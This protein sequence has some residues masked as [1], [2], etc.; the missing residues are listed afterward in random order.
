M[1]QTITHFLSLLLYG[2]F[3]VNLS[4]QAQVAGIY[5]SYIA[6]N[7]NGSGNQFYDLAASTSNPDF[8]GQNL[9][10]F[11]NS[12]SLIISGGQNKTFKS[13]SGGC[14][15]SNGTLHY[16]LYPTASPSGVF[17]GINLLFD[18]NLSGSPIGSQN[19]QWGMGGANPYLTTPNLLTGLTNGDYTLEVYTS[20]NYE[21]CAGNSPNTG[22]AFSSNFGANFKAEF[23]VFNPPV[24]GTNIP[25]E[26][27]LSGNPASE[28]DLPTPTAGDLSIQGFATDISYNRG[29]TAVFKIKTDASAY[30]IKIYRLGYYQGNG[31]RYIADATITTTLP[32][33]QPACITETSTA[34]QLVDCGN[35]AES[36]TWNIP[37]NA[38]SG[39]YI[40]KLIRTDNGGAS[41]IAFIVRNDASTSDLLFQTS[42]ATWQ[43]YNGYDEGSNNTSLYTGPTSL[44]S[45][46]SGKVSYNRPFTTRSGGAGG[47][48][49]E[50]WLFNSEY[51]MIRWL[52]RNGY[53]VSYTT[54]IDTDRHGDLIVNHK[55][56]LSV[57]HDEYWSKGMKDKVTAA[58][59]AGV[60]LAFFSGNEV[61][62]KTRWENSIDGNGTPFRTLVCYKEGPGGEN[63]TEVK[64]DPS[65]EW[66]GLWRYGC[67][68]DYN[69][70][71]NNA[72]L[73]ENEL[74]GQVS[75]DGTTGTMVV[76]SDYK[77]LR[78]WR[79]TDVAN[80]PNGQTLTLTQN[81]LGYEWD[82]E[83]EEFRAS[84]P[85]GRILLSKTI[86]ND[87]THHLSLYKH[88]SGAL[89]FGA[90]TVQ[91]TWGLDE[92]HDRFNGETVSV[93]MQQATVNV[94]ADMDVQATTLQSGL[95]AA[96]AST[97]TQA[98]ISIITNPLN[99][100]DIPN[101]TPIIISGTASD[102][103]GVLAGVEVS[104]DNGT[105]WRVATGAT[106]WTFSWIPTNLG[107]AII[108]VR[109]FDDSGNIE[110]P[111]TVGSNVLTV[112]V[113]TPPPPICPCNV[114]Q[115]STTP[116]NT[117][118]NDGQPIQVG[119]KFRSSIDGFIS[120]ARFYKQ[121]GN[122]GTH[123][124]Q[125]YSNTGAL[126]AQATFIN[127]SASA[128]QEVAFST[129]IAIT[130]NTIYIISYHSAS[131]S[132]SADDNGFV[133]GVAN[134]NL[135]AFADSEVS[136]GN[137]VYKYGALGFP[138]L[139]FEESNYF[140]DVVFNTEIGPD[141]TPPTILLTSPVDNVSNV[142][143][144]ANITVTFS[145]AINPTTLDNSTFSVN[146]V[147]GAVTY[148][149]I[150]KT[151]TFNPNSALSYA[152]TYTATVQGDNDGVEDL[153]GNKIEA[154]FIFSFTTQNAPPPALPDPN[155]GPGGPIL[156]VSSA[157]NPFSRFAVEILRAEGLNEFAGKD[158]S[159]V[160]ASLLNNYDIV[161]LGEMPLN[162]S[163]VSIFSDWV[164]AGGT[165]ITF[166]P[167]ADLATLLGINIGGGTLSDKYLAIANSGAGAGIVNQS[168]Q[169]HGEADLYSLNGA[170]SLATLYSSANTATTNPA[171]T[172]HN[173]GTNGGKAIAFAF[174]LARS[175][176][177]T[178][179]GNPDWAGQKRDGE[180]QP[181]RS[182][183]LFFPDWIDFNKVQ[184]PQADE[185]QRF[186][187]NLIL[188]S[189]AHRKPLPRFWYLPR[190]L[191]AA[192][193]MTGDDHASGGTVGRFNQYL[194]LSSSNT[195][196]AV[197][198]W[199]AIRGTSYIYPNTPM[200]DAE[201]L[202]FENQGF[203]ISL[204]LNTNCAVWVPTSLRNFFDTQMADLAAQF[205]SISPPSTHRTHCI[206]W[207]D[208][209]TTPIVQVERGIRLDANYYY[210]PSAWVQNRPGMF[211]GSGMPMR[212]ADLD[213]TL[214]DCYQL[215]TQLTDESGITY[216]THINTLLDNAI[217]ANG[218]YGVFCANMHTDQ[219]GGNSTQGSNAIISSAQA[220]NIPVIAA[221]QMLTWLDGRNNS[222]FG[223]ITWNGNALSFTANI[224][225]GANLIYGMLPANHQGGQL[226]S[227]TF[228]GGAVSFT[229]E[230]IKG[231]EYAFF[232]VNNGNYVATYGIDNVPPQIT[233]INANPSQGGNATITW[234]TD[235]NATSQVIYGTD[236]NNLNLS[237]SNSSPTTNHSL[238]LTGLADNTQ[239]YYRVISTDASANTGTNPNPPA[240]PLSF[241][242]PTPPVAPCVQDNVVADF[243]LGTSDANTI[244]LG[245][246][247][248]EVS[249]KPAVLEEFTVPS[250]PVGWSGGTW[251]SGG[252]TTFTNGQITVNGTNIYTNSSFEAGTTLEFAATF[253]QGNFQN[254]GFSGNGQFNDPWVVIGRGN[255]GGD[256]GLYARGSSGEAVLLGS[257]LLNTLHRYKIQW[258]SNGSFQFYVD[259][260][261]INAAGF[262]QTVGGTTMIIQI[263]DF[264]VDGANLSVDW[265]SSTP[266]AGSGTFTSRIFDASTA[267]NWLQANW[268]AETPAGT[269]LQIFQRQGNTTTPDGTWTSFTAITNGANVGGT[270]RYI[271]YQMN[272]ATSNTTVS[273]VFKDITIACENPS[274]TTPNIT[275]Q[276]L[277]QTKC[278]G[279]EVTFSSTASGLPEPTV[280]W[281]VSTDNGDN[282]NDI[283]G[284]TNS[285]L[286]FNTVI[287]DN[288]KKY[289]AVWTNTQG[290]INSDEVILT[291]QA[292][293]TATI[294]L[295][296]TQLCEGENITLQLQNAT[297]TAPFDL[298]V[299]GISY[300]DV[301]IGQTFA[302]IDPIPTQSIWDNS[303]VPTGNL[304]VSDGQALEI[305]VK[306]RTSANGYV[307]GVRFYK[308]ATNI[309][310]HIGK[311]W[312]VNG[313]LLANATF[314]NETAEGWQE[315]R[316]SNPVWIQANTT[317][318]ASYFSQNG[319][320][321]ILGGGMN[322]GFTNGNIT[323]L[324]NGTDGPNSV[325]N[326]VGG[327]GGFPDQNGS[328]ANYW[329]DVVFSASLSSPLNS[330]FALTSITDA[331]NCI[332]TGTPLQNISATVN[333]LP[334]GTIAPVQ[335]TV[336]VGQNVNLIFNA[337]NGTAPFDLT[338]NGNVYSGIQ[339]N[340]PFNV[341]VP[342]VSAPSPISIWD[343]NVIGGEPGVVDNSALELGVKFRSHV[344]GKIKGI[345][346][347]KRPLNTGTH[348][349][350]L[351]TLGGT[352]LAT[353]T[354]INESASGWQEVLFDTPVSIQANTTYIASYFAPG[355][356][357]AFTV[358]FFTN[359]GLSN[360]AL[361][362][363]QSGESGSGANGVF[364]EGA[365]FP[366]NSFNDANYWVD[367][368]FVPDGQLLNYNL[369]QIATEACSNT[370][371]LNTVVFVEFDNT[372]PTTPVLSVGTITENSIQLNWT[373]SMDNVEVT[374]YE[375]FQNNVSIGTTANLT[376][377]VSGLTACTAY[378]FTVKTKDAAGNISEASNVLNASTTDSTAPT[379]P[380]LAD[381]TGE[382]AVTVTAPTTTDNCA[383]E[384]IGTTS[385]PLEY[386]AQGTYQITWTFDDGNGNSTQAVQNVVVD[387]VTAPVT[388]VL[389]DATGECA[390][391]VT[392][393]TT[394][395]VCAG[396]IT[397]TTT[398]ALTYTAQGTYQ[399][400]W[401][402]DDGN[403]NS[404]TA[405]QN[406]VVDDVTPPAT[407]TL[408]DA[409]SECAV[410]VTAPTTTDNCA[411]TITGTT[412]DPLD[413]T[414]QGT[415]Q[416]TWTF[417]DGN[418]NSTTAIQNVV[419]DDVTTPVTPTLADAT[420]E[421][422]LTITAPT[423]TDNC[424]GTITGTTSDPLDYTAQGTYQITW[425][426]DDGNGNSTTAIQNVVVNPLTGVSIGS[427]APV[428]KDTPAFALTG[429]PANGTFSGTGVSNGV[430]NPCTAGAGSHTITYTYT[431]ES[432]CTATATTS[433]QVND[434]FC[435][436]CSTPTNVQVAN[437][438][439]TTATLSW[440]VVAGATHYRLRYRVV[441]N[442][443]WQLVQV[444]P[445][446]PYTL[447]GLTAN[448]TYEFQ[449]R[450][451][452]CGGRTSGFSPLQVFV[453][454]IDTQT[455]CG[456]P[457]NISTTNITANSA[458]ASWTAIAS[459]VN[460][461]L[462][463]RVVGASSWTF[464]NTIPSNTQILNGLTATTNYEYQVRSECGG[465]VVSTYSGMNYFTTTAGNAGCGVPTNLTVS[466]ISTSGVT[467][468]WTVVGG[469]TNYRLRYRVVGTT[470][471]LYRTT[472]PTS[473]FVLNNLLANTSYEY[474]LRAECSGVNGN[475]TAIQT[476]TTANAAGR[477][478]VISADLPTV[479]TI[480]EL[481]PNPAKGVVK[482]KIYAPEASVVEVALISV[483][484]VVTTTEKLNTQ[485]GWQEYS[486][487][488]QGK[489]KG[490]YWVK[491]VM[492]AGEI[493]MKKLLLE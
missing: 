352:A 391:T 233:N 360:G 250:L 138:N 316:F 267:K 221:K 377:T 292:N 28:W 97:D 344:S 483:L 2:V 153:A 37:N 139:N 341:G 63:T 362:A 214:I 241:T 89:V 204:H 374:E 351:W 226:Q 27:A 23:T 277:A 315:V 25:T 338:I 94:L 479:F 156:V 350:T 13:L 248:G 407:P 431:R 456:V 355:G 92:N 155:E 469:A 136:G 356:Q 281:Q 452:C 300:P 73:P 445:N 190:K 349:G 14:N 383:G 82:W 36:A 477:E 464:I 297:G 134:G 118:Q 42:D 266:F 98:P 35:W 100:A 170:T 449:L 183:D 91:W 291:V 55:V 62:W 127:E 411:G 398:D 129:P 290:S 107:Q 169:F 314:T 47:G 109:G 310:T 193:V 287:A 444:I 105:T 378:T 210:W 438:T 397:G 434:S 102:T 159:E 284:A 172:L 135:Y 421:C 158:I 406:V 145:E 114:F 79:N 12:Q 95:V 120:G 335:A 103:G 321:A 361:R 231:I 418:G 166:R 44:P 280:Q 160:N 212:F 353:A 403:G 326:Y 455:G 414:A 282:W 121:A 3:A 8:D 269:T 227:L 218:Y 327:T 74:T 303:F 358:N 433:I 34:I 413:Y 424:A 191:K 65:P 201:A 117:L 289:R 375:I 439:N 251:N 322:T 146:G 244:V 90:G 76:P 51:P 440:N 427:Y 443:N 467:F 305:G 68:P 176:V 466:N 393:P 478:A 45:G 416:I 197:A 151:A 400:T 17:I 96:T 373:A 298:V 185:Q 364:K 77:N 476:F 268:T 319:F 213:G 180:Q 492:P 187:A 31:A 429:S 388:P 126:L 171:V 11:A 66:T 430:F 475:Y 301:N 334:S 409:T 40:A 52:E 288:G 275:L 83:Q 202:A 161:I 307:K 46:H 211:T 123:T 237:A 441:G 104:T 363:L 203:E 337:T 149:E 198:N 71:T 30:Q 419:V 485:K 331:G 480:A 264:P 354:F 238:N 24:F 75:W 215:T 488:L 493:V 389:A 405:I 206:S 490:V 402:F 9:G 4:V 184:I 408:A 451:E 228:N 260:A 101:H 174:D 60:H 192:V 235:E 61:Y 458:T 396:T 320:F 259:N 252:G 147:S 167:D 365:G 154:D 276:P 487:S 57:G 385:D 465:G 225:A 271:Q 428:C 242:T 168:M 131:G 426:F 256:N 442:T 108:K 468:S 261:L 223:A 367:V 43:A 372:A 278:E 370:V 302:T 357:Y 38:I 220:K 157:S 70:A 447:T 471:W 99:N 247:G 20:A 115:A 122:T 313:T 224:F 420:G 175:I 246:E 249:L 72:C 194:S 10:V 457:L 450:S 229:I 18:Q 399:I 311:L 144:N 5:E 205:P 387:D 376:F 234:N 295:A 41:H 164:N 368:V 459:A 209:A 124:A 299:N 415:Y 462:R 324:A 207:S 150:S 240:N 328:G 88:S 80:L 140:V 152:T 32:Q 132:Y 348:T 448:R 141:T 196:Q 78:F 208:W 173:V 133:Q 404:T 345:R 217:G 359:S 59:N 308:G 435:L 294:A 116:S 219:N 258:N 232:P 69:P 263:S 33:T 67:L 491:V 384:I 332:N 7:V 392:A 125:L 285:N 195:A 470:T 296:D 181:I 343:N 309:G 381:A 199:E 293:P 182:D 177:Y 6:L 245:L 333:P 64:S 423:T 279:Q 179:Q 1:K 253:T 417:D 432:G 347:Y 236:A 148:D 186:L 336:L 54:N 113:V 230:I 106:N 379:T 323:L 222:S 130:A 481:Y 265:I 446:T 369:T 272:L 461:K 16:R 463:Y 216:S 142:N 380:T 371:N 254:I 26:N 412:S 454:P 312:S 482:L 472:I 318:I 112:N 366:N 270:S 329:V 382:C 86:H 58:R 162:I 436:T 484:G 473:P 486:L 56:F 178:R 19:Q 110:I 143:I 386:T 85:A 50:D 189:N 21:N 22:T 87:K 257:N 401:T 422:S 262:T 306:F 474:Q 283:N 49:Q 84:Y 340:T 437:I 137:G 460:Y 304:S 93:A 255:I 342:N 489:A 410:T 48:A 325:F 395:D 394:T 390:V 15:V 346:F 39:I 163:E 53:D 239:Y 188:Q 425:T 453:T 274:N 111:T 243:N 339:N 81:T 273:P 165:L 286:T 119:M 128:W 317:Y 330:N 29:E 200:T